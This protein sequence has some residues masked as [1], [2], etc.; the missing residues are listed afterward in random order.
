MSALTELPTEILLRIL[1][2]LHRR[3]L[4]KVRLVNKRLCS[5]AEG[6][7]FHAIYPKRN[8][9]SFYN[10]RTISGNPN[11]GKHV[12][13]LVYSGRIVS[14]PEEGFDE[15]F[16]NVLGPDNFYERDYNRFRGFDSEGLADFFRPTCKLSYGER[17][18]DHFARET[19]ELTEAF[20][21]FPCLG[22]LL[23]ETT[24]VSPYF[25]MPKFGERFTSLEDSEGNHF[26]GSQIKAL[27]T[28]AFDA[29]KELKS[30]EVLGLPRRSIEDMTWPVNI[31]GQVL[32]QCR[33][34]KIPR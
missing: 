18:V 20:R 3:R 7:L 4:K 34:F 13:R 1:Q 23:L 27:L 30:F 10:L 15:Y 5:V 12:R 22:A 6:L 32:Q 24:T 26:Q 9:E 31:M 2:H 17:L 11:F 19:K 16:R 14:I 29:G 21:L 33:Q 25:M 28:A 8:I